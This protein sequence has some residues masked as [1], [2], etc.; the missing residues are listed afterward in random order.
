MEHFQIQKK[1][2]T[3][4]WTVYSLSQASLNYYNRD[5]KLCVW[6]L[7]N[8]SK[9]TKLVCC[10]HLKYPCGQ[11]YLWQY[12]FIHVCVW[13]IML[14]DYCIFVYICTSHP[15]IPNVFIIINYAKY[16]KINSYCPYSNNC[17]FREHSTFCLS[18]L[19]STIFR[20]PYLENIFI[21]QLNV[22]IPITLYYTFEK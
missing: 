1:S 17:T 10:S 12:I 15:K 19:K 7:Q 20:N 16:V 9:N 2:L 21:F 5:T 18:R 14:I 8:S 6:L 11:L 4:Q 3:T 22:S 13:Q